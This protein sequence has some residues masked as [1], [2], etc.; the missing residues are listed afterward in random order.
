MLL[1]L[2]EEHIHAMVDENDDPNRVHR[3]FENVVLA[4]KIV[5]L[6]EDLRAYGCFNSGLNLAESAPTGDHMFR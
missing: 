2:K 5:E 1:S 6:I 4:L 3:S